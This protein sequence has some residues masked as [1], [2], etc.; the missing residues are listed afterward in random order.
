MHLVGSKGALA[1]RGQT[2]GFV[3]LSSGLRGRMLRRF[4][5]VTARPAVCPVL[6]FVRKYVDRW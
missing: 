2:L 6:R 4:C 5:H 1:I 3:G